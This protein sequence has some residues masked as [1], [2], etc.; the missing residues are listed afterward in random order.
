MYNRPNLGKRETKSVNRRVRY[1]SIIWKRFY[2]L[3]ILVLLRVFNVGA[4]GRISHQIMQTKSFS[5]TCFKSIA[6]GHELKS[7]YMC[8]IIGFVGGALFQRSIRQ[9]GNIKNIP[10]RLE[11]DLKAS[12]EKDLL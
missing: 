1:L 12:M 4:W 11:S 8:G 3:S 9:K 6:C 10:A 5:L 2:N 7:T